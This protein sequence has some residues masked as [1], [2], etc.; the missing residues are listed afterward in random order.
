MR[1]NLNNL[2]QRWYSLEAGR[3]G[4]G[5]QAYVIQE[6]C[7]SL[8]PHC[9]GDGS[10]KLL[11]DVILPEFLYSSLV[12]LS[13]HGEVSS[14]LAAHLFVL[15]QTFRICTQEAPAKSP[16]RS[17]PNPQASWNEPDN[18]FQDPSRA[19]CSP[20]PD[21]HP[22]QSTLWFL[23]HRPPGWVQRTMKMITI[24]SVEPDYTA[25]KWNGVKEWYLEAELLSNKK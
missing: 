5:T 18:D 21:M 12:M 15:M 2:P 13:G 16:S 14:L 3:T 20:S 8:P 22:P 23:T 10:L 6:H 7:F 9:H 17:S 1:H 24:D 11:C 25:N 4:N 19:R